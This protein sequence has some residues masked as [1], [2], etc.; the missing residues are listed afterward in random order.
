MH[1]DDAEAIV[2]ELRQVADIRIRAMVGGW[3]V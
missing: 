1:R 3:L 2:A